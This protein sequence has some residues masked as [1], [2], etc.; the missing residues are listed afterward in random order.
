MFV[1]RAGALCASMSWTVLL[2]S[3]SPCEATLASRLNESHLTTGTH[4]S[5]SLVWHFG[6]HCTLR[7]VR[8]P[9]LLL[10]LFPSLLLLAASYLFMP[11]LNFSAVKGPSDGLSSCL[12]AVYYVMAV[13]VPSVLLVHAYPD[14]PRCS[15]PRHSVIPQ[16]SVEFGALHIYAIRCTNRV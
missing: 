1:V 12:L 14:W 4:G 3:I 8:Y 13:S 10:S 2:L 15:L 7:C 5:T 16:A 11:C 6:A 9:R